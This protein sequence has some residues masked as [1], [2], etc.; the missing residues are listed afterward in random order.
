MKLKLTIHEITLAYDAVDN[1]P[2]LQLIAQPILEILDVEEYKD[3]YEL[4]FENAEFEN[5]RIAVNQY[6]NIALNHEVKSDL[7]VLAA[8]LNIIR[9]TL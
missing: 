4:E 3:G 5:I 1:T 6:S 8:K 2:E 7:K 9:Q